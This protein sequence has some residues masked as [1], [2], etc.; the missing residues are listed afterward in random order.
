MS[1]PRQDGVA[2]V[3]AIEAIALALLDDHVAGLSAEARV[4]FRGKV[5]QTVKAEGAA[6]LKLANNAA[7]AQAAEL[8]AARALTLAGEYVDAAVAR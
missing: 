8:G 5:E 4:V 7:E 2:R 1:T 6:L 3:M